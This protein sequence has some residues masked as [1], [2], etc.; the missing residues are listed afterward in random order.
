MLRI[1]PLLLPCLSSAGF[2]ALQHLSVGPSITT[3]SHIPGLPPCGSC[4]LEW[5]SC[6]LSLT[7]SSS[8]LT[9]NAQLVQNFH[10]FF[11]HSACSFSHF[12]SVSFAVTDC[13]PLPPPPLPPT[14]SSPFLFLLPPPPHPPP[15]SPHRDS[16]GPQRVRRRSHV[17]VWITEGG[18]NLRARSCHSYQEHKSPGEGRAGG[19]A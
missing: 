15:P 8:K 1:R 5:N 12:P 19:G 16:A 11:L 18:N 4:G 2:S 13:P 6:N 9:S 14:P 7:C 17:T 10:S 3:A